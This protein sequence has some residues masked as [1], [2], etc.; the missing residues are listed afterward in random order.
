LAVVDDAFSRAVPPLTI[1][2]FVL[3]ALLLV[4]VTGIPTWPWTD[5]PVLLS[6]ATDLSV[7]LALLL[8]FL[9]GADLR[10]RQGRAG[11]LL[12]PLFGTAA[13]L[14]IFRSRGALLALAAGAFMVRPRPERALKGL[15]GAVAVAL[16]LYVSGV[17]FTVGERQVSFQH[18]VESAASLLG[19]P[20]ESADSIYVATRN[21]RTDWWDDIW[22]D[23]RAQRM[24]LHGHGW[25]DNLA[26]R[27][28]LVPQSASNQPRVLR[29]PHNIFFSLAGR[30]GLL[31]AVGFL[32]V[33]VVTAARTFRIGDDARRSLAVGAARGGIVAA[34]VVALSDVYLESPQGGILYWS[35][36]GLL[37]WAS[38][39]G[40]PAPDQA[41]TGRRAR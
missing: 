22:T 9:V 16:T 21:W 3:A 17:S 10:P 23:V 38:A 12:L 36:I 18:I 20:G 41:A 24:V 14:V 28:G 34:V 26:V 33:P 2:A 25:G 8:P 11:R 7:T 29:A 15:F 37:W 32:V 19:G 4:T 30:A 35:L 6:K 13:L 27:H 5:A 40:L 39:P 1:A 31:T